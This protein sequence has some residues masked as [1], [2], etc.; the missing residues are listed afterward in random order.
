M[1]EQDTRAKAKRRKHDA[2]FK[3]ELIERCL[4]LG[5]SVS[6]IALESGLNA[7][8]LFKWRRMHLRSNSPGAREPVR[9]EASKMLPVM[10]RASAVGEMTAQLPM[11]RSPGLI[12][13]DIGAARVRVRGA[14]DEAN[15]RCVLQ[16]L[17]AQR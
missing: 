13:I 16:A 1:I 3:R 4:H 14:V 12:E 10:I 9:G 2:A 6:A 15:L 7:N 5:A 17:G 8:L 11:P